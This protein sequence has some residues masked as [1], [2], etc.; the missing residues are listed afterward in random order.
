MDQVMKIGGVEVTTL[1]EKCG[2]P[3]FV[4]DEEALD[5]KIN[6][7]VDH[8]KSDAFTTEVIYASKAFTC[9]E[10][11]KKIKDRCSLD[12]VSGGELFVAKQAGFDC[13]KIYFHGN[14]KTRKEI[15]LALQY[16]VKTFVLDN[17]DEVALLKQESKNMTHKTHVLIRIN[18]KVERHTHE[19]I[20]TATGD[21]K[22]GIS[23]DLK[24][25][26]K[27]MIQEIK[28]SDTLVFDGF[29]SHIG[30][31][32]FERE[33]FVAAIDKMIDFA[34]KMSKEMNVN[35]H[36]MN[37]GGGFGVTYTSEDIPTPT[38]LMCET[39][40]Q[41]VEEACDKYELHVSNVCIEPGRSIVAE[42]GIHYMKL[43]LQR[44]H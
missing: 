29:H 12:V 1:K 8:F 35:I 11:I 6:E 44:R 2:T 3:L 14:N 38:P 27:S 16:G 33:A 5:Y 43:V 23:I 20:M 36:T 42:E 41:A 7:Y 39:L 4:Y 30:S 34:S 26:I 21:S 13:N 24:A 19:F 37:L 22:F 31:Q 10:M 25:E 32:I 9:V 17:V 18:P 15:Q 28:N 40:I